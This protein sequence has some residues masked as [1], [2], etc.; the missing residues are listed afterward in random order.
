[1]S[2]FKK[3]LPKANQRQKDSVK[4]WIRNEQKL[5]KLWNIPS[6]IQSLCIIYF[7]EYDE[8]STENC[9]ALV[10]ISNDKTSITKRE[11]NLSNLYCFGTLRIP[12]LN[13]NNIYRWDVQIIKWTPGVHGF[14]NAMIGVS[15]RTKLWKSPGTNLTP[16]CRALEYAYGDTGKIMN[17]AWYS[18]TRDR[19]SDYGDKAKENDIISVELD[20]GDSTVRFY[21]NDKDQGIA[22]KDIKKGEDIQYRFIF[23]ALCDG[24]ELKLM[25]FTTR[26]SKED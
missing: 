6:L 8:L 25:N 15:S 2:L 26:Y 19:W 11:T 4:G 23:G 17:P 13:N 1:M 9:G 7:N 20:I 14:D 18:R 10:D 22:Y 21:V 5:N 24:T 3:H 16:Y 12:S